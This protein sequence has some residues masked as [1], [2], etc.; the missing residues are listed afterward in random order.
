MITS[1]EADYYKLAEMMAPQQSPKP[2]RGTMGAA[3]TDPVFKDVNGNPITSIAC[4][5]TYTFDVPGYSQIWLTML[6]DGVKTFDQLFSVP[7]PSYVSSCANDVGTYQVVAYDPVSGMVIGK[8][9]FTVLPS[10]GAGQSVSSFFGSLTPIQIG[11]G[12]AV[13]FFM[14]KGK[15]RR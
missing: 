15:K 14:L 3:A 10:S 6:K 1:T 7:M 4:G 2:A 12:A 8:T 5:G 13:L 9:N 11:I